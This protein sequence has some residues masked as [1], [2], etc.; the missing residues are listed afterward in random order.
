MEGYKYLAT[1]ILT[2]VI[3]DVI[4]DLTFNFYQAYFPK[5][6]R[7]ENR[8]NKLTA[9]ESKILLKAIV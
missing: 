1:Y 3:E 2:T 9:L 6:P 8:W 7:P 4:E 5:R